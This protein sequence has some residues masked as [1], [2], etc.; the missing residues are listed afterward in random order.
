MHQSQ[1]PLDP[2]FVAAER[3]PGTGIHVPSFLGRR[4]EAPGTLIETVPRLPGHRIHQKKD[5]IPKL[6]RNHSTLIHCCPLA[7][8]RPQSVHLFKSFAAKHTLSPSHMHRYGHPRKGALQGLLTCYH[9]VLLALHIAFRNQL[10]SHG[11]FHLLLDAR[12][13]SCHHSQFFTLKL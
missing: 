1:Q 10:F 8:P 5:R 11:C 12:G 7:D 6:L 2:T 3:Y 4:R 13:A 9:Q